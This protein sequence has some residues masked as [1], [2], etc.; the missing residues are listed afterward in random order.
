MNVLSVTLTSDNT[1][2]AF[3]QSTQVS[4]SDENPIG[5]NRPLNKSPSIALLSP[6][7]T[8]DDPYLNL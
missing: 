7:I 5:K 1:E 3:S 4:L 6:H 8:S 2:Q